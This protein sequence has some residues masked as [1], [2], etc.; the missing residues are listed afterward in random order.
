MPTKP[1]PPKLAKERPHDAQAVLSR[2][3]LC[4][5]GMIAATGLFGV[6]AILTAAD[7]VITWADPKGGASGNLPPILTTRERVARSIAPASIVATCTV[8]YAFCIG[9]FIRAMSR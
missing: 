5:A 6:I 2:R 8:G 4:V 9:Y 1:E 7:L 3:D